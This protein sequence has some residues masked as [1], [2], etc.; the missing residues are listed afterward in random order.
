MKSVAGGRLAAI[1]L[2]ASGAIFPAAAQVPTREEIE[3]T[4]PDP[5]APQGPR[6]KVE[7]GALRSPCPLAEDRFRDV[8]ITIDEVAFDGLRGLPL[9]ALRPSY[10]AYLGHA[11][12]VAAICEIRDAAA[13]IIRSQGYVA[14]VQVPPQRID[15]GKVHLTVLM[16]KLVDIRVRGDAR[17]AERRIAAYLGA[18]KSQEVFNERDAERYLLLARD[19]PGYDVRL[20]LRPADGAPGEVVGEVLVTRTPID[21]DFSGQNFGSHSVGRWG[22]LL[23][24]Q[25]YGLTGFGDRT[26]LG[27]FSTADVDEQQVVQASHD[28]RLGHEGL[29]LG[30]R[31]TYAWTHPDVPDL[32]VTAHTLLASAEAS[33]PFIRSQTANLRGS[34]GLDYINQKVSANGAPNSLDRIRVAYLR[35][36]AEA[37]DPASVEGR[38]GY[39]SGE[40]RWRWAASLELRRGLA[41]LDA[42]K[43]CAGVCGTSVIGPSRQDGDP[44][45][46]VARLSGVIEYRPRPKIAF[47]L[48][49]R[50]QYAERPL[51][52]FE[53][54]SAGT[55]TVGR[56]Y[57]AGTLT[58]DSGAGFQLEARYGHLAP[59]S[60]ADL[61]LQPFVFTDVARVWNEGTGSE[62]LVSTGGGVRAAWGA[63]ARLDVSLAVPLSRVGLA[64]DR[65]SPRLLLS[66]STKL[67]PWP[68]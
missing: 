2:A 27:I 15:G 58:G 30:G 66:L 56:G 68:K 60:L 33:Y 45:A 5:L 9:A 23:R 54:Y 25:F 53:E 36:D 47:V 42:S 44:T 24:A 7:A 35:A 38:G 6:L 3:R 57:D 50:Y 34:L 13:S 67:W 28:F 49:P 63:R 51:L 62:R 41:I 14:A 21:V 59:R 20:T 40:P 8:T 39:S 19:L 55:Y 65:P 26:S 46:S 4:R 64:N 29:T 52:G 37:V 48:A 43:G 1:M 16:A 32:A 12:P 11:V 10:E 22:G 18:L 31:F 17:G 61:A